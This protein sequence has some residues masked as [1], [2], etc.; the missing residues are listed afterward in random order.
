MVGSCGPVAQTF[1][2]GAPLSAAERRAAAAAAAAA[3]RAA[4][5]TAA[6]APSTPIHLDL[7]C[8]ALDGSVGLDVEVKGEQARLRVAYP[9]PV[10]DYRGRGEGVIDTSIYFDSDNDARSGLEEWDEESLKLKGV[11][12]SLEMSEHPQGDPTIVP[13]FHLNSKVFKHVDTMANATGRYTSEY[14][15][16]VAIFTVDLAELN[17]RRGALVK[18]LFT[19]GK[20]GPVGQSFRM[21][22]AAPGVR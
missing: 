10:I 5:S 21:G 2:L 16:N 14:L 11:D 3:A 7:P 15:G 9:K 12:Y 13:G 22:A 4:S 8:P 20:C 6:K 18:A 19:V 17:I 1:R